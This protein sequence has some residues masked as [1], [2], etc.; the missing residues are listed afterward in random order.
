MKIVIIRQDHLGDLVLTTPLIRALSLAGHQVTVI[1]RRSNLPIME[2]NPHLHFLIALEEIVPSFPRHS[3]KLGMAVRKL[4]PDLVIVPHARPLNLIVGLRCGYFGPILSMWGGIAAL[5]LFCRNLRTQLDRNPRHMADLCLDFAR[6]LKADEK[7]LVPEV[8]VSD[9]EKNR[10]REM[11]IEKFG[12]CRLVIIHPGCSGNT[13]NLPP[14]IYAELARIVIQK[15]DYDVIV[16]GSTLEKNNRENMVFEGI[17]SQGYWNSMGNFSLRELAVVISIA[18]V[19]VSVGTGPMHIASALGV[20]TVSPFCKRVGI[21]K[22]VW[23]NL[24]AISS[25][26]EPDGIDCRSRSN[27]THC[28]YEN[29]ITAEMLYAQ[30]V[31]ILRL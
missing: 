5:S 15:T 13:C 26:L 20:P 11:V 9:A 6:Q 17:N 16:T 1:A 21:C 19:L 18:D 12:R 24:G 8:F 3:W 4:S 30:I 14:N 10:I 29:Q 22:E 23:G 28:N 25:E 27:T 31:N 2:K 7:G